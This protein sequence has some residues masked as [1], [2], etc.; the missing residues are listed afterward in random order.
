MSE[1][2]LMRRLAKPMLFAAALIW[3]SSF[4]LMKDSLDTLPVQYL[5]A[6]RFTIGTVLMTLFCWNR[7][8]FQNMILFAFPLRRSG[9]LM[10]ERILRL[11]KRIA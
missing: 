9:E 7:W 3:G 1:K 4:F 10:S 6:F 2:P 11:Q 5:L 8:K